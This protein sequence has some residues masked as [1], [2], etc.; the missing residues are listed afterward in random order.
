MQAELVI[1]ALEMV[2]ALENETSS[3]RR[4]RSSAAR[5][6]PRSRTRLTT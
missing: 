1:D 3:T 6:P 5:H 4:R 2:E